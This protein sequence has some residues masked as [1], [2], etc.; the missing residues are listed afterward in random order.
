MHNI[1]SS[2]SALRGIRGVV[3]AVFFLLTLFIT[4][5]QPT[6]QP[7]NNLPTTM[8]TAAIAAVVPTLT[9][10]MTPTPL[11]STIELISPSDGDTIDLGQP[12]NFIVSA[13]HPDGIRL[14]TLTSNGQGVGLLQNSGDIQVEM[15]QTWTPEYAG[16]HEI[17]AVVT[18]RNGDTLATEPIYIRVVDRDMMARNAPIWANVEANVIDLRNLA[19]L[20]PVE[21]TLLSQSELRQR[22]TSNYFYT[23]EEADRDALVLYTFDFVSRDYDLYSLSRRFLGENIAGFYDPESKEFVVVSSDD[24]T[25]AL[26]QWTYAHEFMHALQDQHFQLGL[27]TDASAGF[28]GDMALRALAEGEAELVQ[29]FYLDWGYFSDSD[30]IEI[31]NESN[32]L[33]GFAFVSDPGYFPHA[34]TNA[35]IFPYTTG[36]D[37]A[38]ALFNRSGWDGLNAAWENLPQSTEQII[39]PDR[40]F[41]GDNPQ[42]VTLPPLTDTLGSDW[43]LVEE[44]VLGEFYLREYLIQQVNGS[45]VDTAATGWG[46]D[47]Y[48]VYW[49]E[50]SDDLVLVLRTAW[51]SAGDASQFTAAYT[52]Y[53][54]GRYGPIGQSQADGAIC[55]QSRDATCLYAAGTELLVVRAPDLDTAVAIVTT[56]NEG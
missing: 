51:D 55:W 11:P 50:E 44:A 30:L 22:L 34:L 26:E 40:Y 12:I 9:P 35:F 48:A 18:S 42:I 33:Y 3:T 16:T 14:I 53:T 25:N 27:I 29:D 31:F 17:I 8:P 41:A 4:G 13:S 28:E 32:K 43:S 52:D 47:R 5:C 19:P 15:N 54:D 39:H 37:F 24:E 6:N 10:T 7:T 20:E 38:A 21:P 49:H 1:N 36:H 45:E 23:K 2:H 56:I 46:G